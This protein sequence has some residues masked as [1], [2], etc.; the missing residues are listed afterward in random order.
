M[1]SVKIDTSG[2]G[3]NGLANYGDAERLKL[4]YRMLFTLQKDALKGNELALIICVDLH[5]ALNPD[6]HVVTKKQFACITRHLIEGYTVDEV[7]RELKCTQKTVKDHIKRGL[8]NISIALDN[9]DVYNNKTDF[10]LKN[11]KT[12]TLQE[13]ADALNMTKGA[14][15]SRIHR[16]RKSGEIN[17]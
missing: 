12:M 7:A 14:V 9:G 2:G 1:G 15:K 8:K 3:L 6:K 13:I 4:L 5:T 10:I 11:H 16:M 17:D